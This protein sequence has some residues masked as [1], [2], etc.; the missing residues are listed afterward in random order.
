MGIE[1]TRKGN[2]FFIRLLVTLVIS[3]LTVYGPAQDRLPVWPYLFVAF[4]LS[5][6]LLAARLPQRLF[7]NRTV[8]YV[9]VFFDSCMI[10]LGMY[11]SG[12][13][14]TEF[15]LVYFIIIGLASMGTSLRY[16]MINTT[17]F[18]LLYG[19]LLYQKGMLSGDMAVSYSLRLPFMFI[20]ALFF[21]YIVDTLLR[22][23]DRSLRE[24]EEKYRSLIESTD[25]SVYMVSKDGT[26]LSG[27]NKLQTELGL[28][29][30]EFMGRSFAD[31]HS[32][33]E[34]EQFTSMVKE[35]FASEEALR[36]EAYDSRLRKWFMLTLSPIKDPANGRVTAVSVLSK[37]I[38]E[39]ML[40]ERKLRKAYNELR[41]TQEQLIQ[42]AKMSAVGRLASGVA[43]QIRNPLGII[44]MG[45]EFLVDELP[46]KDPM[47]CECMDK[48]KEAS[49]RT[50]R[51]IT[52][53][54]QFSRTSAFELQ[55]VDLCKLLDDAIVLMAH[56]LI[57]SN[58]EIKKEY[59][60]LPVGV[61]GDKNTL[62][63]AFINLLTNAVDAMPEGGKMKIG[64]YPENGKGNVS[65]LE[66]KT[67]A[68]MNGRMTAVQIQDTGKG[69]PHEVLP[70]I[71]EPFFTTKHGA[72]GTGLGLSTAHAI[73]QRH[74]GSLD[75]NSVLG[76]GTTVT[77]KL[78]RAQNPILEV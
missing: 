16:L 37:D 47:L 73:V 59:P 57:I 20:I 3:Y 70:K 28:S 71:F 43:H 77:V 76:E 29:G 17:V 27:N 5:T 62:Q 14:G 32:P 4:Y 63:Q 7:A 11:L 52:D 61:H 15:Y 54:F 67:G 19:W 56:K 65:T 48:I 38:T 41:K 6:N 34:A 69:I 44:V 64:V 66:G 51:I 75:V 13:A 12:R 22:D 18:A 39:R 58:I 10:A 33:K 9:L 1:L 42:S 8:F 23:K 2:I 46:D 49:N 21:G 26:Y 72:Q 25:D 45:V 68:K 35:V 50:N 30:E 55:S 53:F 31:F 74:K 24:S 36:Y 60:G 40:T 78:H